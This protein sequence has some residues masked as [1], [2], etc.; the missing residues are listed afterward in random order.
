MKTQNTLRHRQ[1][2]I[3]LVI[4][5]I[6]LVVIIG[7]AGLALDLGSTML[8]DARLQNAMDACA[9]TGAQ[10]LVDTEGDTTEASDEAKRTFDKNLQHLDDDDWSDV[11]VEF[12]DTL[13]PFNK[14]SYS[15][16]RYVRCAVRDY[17]YK[18]RLAKILGIENLGLNVT[19]VAGLVPETLCNPAPLMV[20]GD[21]NDDCEPCEDNEEPCTCYGFEVYKKDSSDQKE[22]YLKACPPGKPCSET[23]QVA[24]SDYCG[25]QVD[26]PF[27]GG[28]GDPGPGN[29]QYLDME[30]DSGKTGKNCIGEV[31]RGGG[32]VL[33]N[34]CAADDSGVVSE[35][36]NA[37][38]LIRKDF[39]TIFDGPNADP[40]NDYP[41]TYSQYVDA[42]GL[43]VEGGESP[44]R[45]LG[46]VIADCDTPPTPEA[47]ESND[48][49][50]L[51]GKACYRVMTTGCFF[52]TQPG[53][54][55]GG[56]SLVLG[57]FIGQCS[58]EGEMSKKLNAF[59][60]YKIV[61]HKDHLG[62]DS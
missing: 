5:A 41:M 6:G 35:P 38:N 30:C 4:F 18:S 40:V 25:A 61:L 62:P 3:A 29:F 10:V 9:L 37:P 57:Q 13:E 34:G 53:L 44:R 47:C 19:A 26:D 42:K 31:F 60:I 46:V 21:T 14:D 7:I 52:V 28:K 39:N 56:E 17:S 33:V 55:Q 11:A 51:T 43:D 24:T 49:K 45:V 50:K 15:S 20:C 36:G 27:G 2:G 12:S 23:F 16:P 59:D 32:G 48:K 54:E 1:Q 58:G 22:C 8:D